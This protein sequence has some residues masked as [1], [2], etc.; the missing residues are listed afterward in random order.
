MAAQ[1]HAGFL[2]ARLIMGSTGLNTLSVDPP[3]L[4]NLLYSAGSPRRSVGGEPTHSHGGNTG[5]DGKHA[6][7]R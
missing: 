6:V 7:F 2:E 5:E 1:D 4:T 3:P